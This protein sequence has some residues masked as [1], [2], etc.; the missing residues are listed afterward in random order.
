MKWEYLAYAAVAATT[1]AA[2]TG[3]YFY[4]HSNTCASGIILKQVIKKSTY[5][6]IIQEMREFTNSGYQKKLKEFREKRRKLDP[7]SLE[8][9]KLVISFNHESKSLVEQ[10]QELV[11]KKYRLTQSHFEDSVN[12]YDSDPELQN[13]VINVFDTFISV[14]EEQLLGLEETKRILDYYQ[15][16]LKEYES[17]C[18]DLEEY[19]II[20]NK[21]EDEVFKLFSIEIEVMNASWEIYKKEIEDMYEAIRNQTYCV[22]A[23]TDNSF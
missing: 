13:L 6:Q 16:R 8:Y 21:I 4:H 15:S 10:A 17:D 19:M 9:E 12:F 3:A 22:L 1:V 14:K 20:N 7:E 2:I 18:P 5:I 11:L 23:S